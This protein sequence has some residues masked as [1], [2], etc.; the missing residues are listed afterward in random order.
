MKFIQAVVFC[1]S[2]LL[3]LIID[4]FLWTSSW[5]VGLGGLIGIA[6]FFIGYSLADSMD[7]S[8]SDRWHLSKYGVFK[9]KIDY[10]YS[11][12]GIA[13]VIASFI[14]YFVWMVVSDQ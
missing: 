11:I 10:G 3:L 4:V 12:A 2:V 5:C 6:G 7:I 13:T 8:S 9:K 14:V 1:G